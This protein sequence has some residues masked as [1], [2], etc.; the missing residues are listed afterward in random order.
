MSIIVAEALEKTYPG[1]VEAVRGISFSVE[2]GEIFALLG[3]NGAGK[4]STVR[5]LA[6]L[7]RPTAGRAMVA[8]HDTVR[9]PAAVRREIGYV[10]QSSTVDEQL[11]GVENLR[12]QGR[13][14][15]MRGAA[16][17]QR[18]DAL[19]GLLDLEEAA[20]RLARTYS[21]GMR[22]RLDLAMGLIHRPR[23]LFLDE[24]SAGLDPESR[25]TLWSEV[26]R[27]AREDGITVL[28]TTHYLEEADRYARRVAIVDKGR[29]VAEGTPAELKARLEGDAVDIRLGDAAAVAAAQARLGGLDG[30]RKTLVDGTALHIRVP[31][32][33]R[34][35]PAIV[36]ALDGVP[37]EE[38][39]LSR[40]SLDE[41]YLSL[42]G[43]RFAEA[44]AAGATGNGSHRS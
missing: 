6:T 40:P 38:V 34:A 5:M 14:F 28:L 2:E 25:A 3:P 7:A 32:G 39:T 26:T 37:I 8:G 29:I 22:R 18:A 36:A 9:E 13:L 35:I 27:L 30:I 33:A 19:L 11:T 4:S 41:V 12:L 44:D 1:P 15:G 20:G 10:A 43:R 16:L 42:T 24:P 23:V 21:G 31:D 17:R